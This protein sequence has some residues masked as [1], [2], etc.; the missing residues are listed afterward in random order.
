MAQNLVNAL[1]L[2]A[3]YALFAMGLSIAWA[4]LNV[5]NLAHGAIFMVGALTAWL[6]TDSFPGV[7]FFLVLPA[8]VVVCGLIALLMELLVFRP[9]RQRAVDEHQRTLTT[10][11]ATV[12]TAA[13][14]V[15][16]AEQL[17]GGQPRGLP[18]GLFSVQT[19][20]IA[21]VQVTDIQ[22]VIIAVAVLAS[23]GIAWFLTRSR[24]GRALRALSFDRDTAKLT[25]VSVDRLSAL[26][27]T[28]TGAVA[29][30]AGVLLAVQ[31]N[32]VDAT[33]GESLLF[34]A[35]AVIIIAG[36]GSIGA[37]VLAAVALAVIETAVVAYWVSDLRD[38]VVFGLI[39]AFLLV[40]PQGIA[41]R[42]WQ[43]A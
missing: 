3:I 1:S 35:F 33:M 23:A 42:G 14:L 36:V 11:I 39:I 21:G 22:L 34:K 8:A 28:A 16:A 31:V 29:G 25:G 18:E 9:I 41:G 20:R 6:M 13:L 19:F 2:G 12:A 4:G 26:T 38:V 27:I 17:T 40:R 5:L 15:A 37:T 43:R 24:Q 10:V 32:A 30:L 7:S